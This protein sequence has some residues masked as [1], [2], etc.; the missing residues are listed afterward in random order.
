MK[1]QIKGNY[2]V[3]EAEAVT[4][5]YE[6]GGFGRPRDGSLQLR[7][8]EAAYLLSRNKIEIFKSGK[9][10]DFDS[11]IQ[12]AAQQEDFFELK[13]IVYKD[14]KERGYY[15]QSSATD[16][17]VYPR[18]GK[19]GK[20]SAK[21]YVYVRSERMPIPFSELTALMNEAQN[22]RKQFILAVVDEE[23]DITFYDVK[24][25]DAVGNFEGGMVLPYPEDVKKKTPA[26]AVLFKERVILADKETADLLYNRAF[27][28][29]MMD[30]E[31]LLLSL[32]EAQYLA[33]NGVLELY[34]MDGKALSL[35]E[36]SKSASLIDSEFLKKYTIYK[37][38]KEKGF[39]PKTGFKFG[40]HFRVYRKVDSLDKI[41]HSEFLLHVVSLEF[42]FKLPATSGAIRLANSVR[43][44][45][46]YAADL[47]SRREY[48]EF[49]RIKM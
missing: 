27:F 15:V 20:T 21:S 22:V 12:F 38:L 35:E 26:K 29:K 36:F 4:A 48:I 19:P 2:V 11:F 10:L 14:L 45:M 43:K 25:A 3:G 40:T 34:D 39:V 23:S 16:F 46:I 6:T 31:R 37:E 24:R 1:T 49:E 44:R 28:G 13:F 17:R 9:E 8:V 18:G 47:G 5:L 32:P 30:E 42:E 7:F 41:P 33:E